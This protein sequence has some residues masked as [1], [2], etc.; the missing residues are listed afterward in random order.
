[1][2]EKIESLEVSSE[3]GQVQIY[4]QDF[5]LDKR[6]QRHQEELDT[7]ERQINEL[8]RQQTEK[9]QQW[10]T[11]KANIDQKYEKEREIQEQNLRMTQEENM[12]INKEIQQTKQRKQKLKQIEKLI[13]TISYTNIQIELMRDFIVPK[14]ALLGDYVE[15]TVENILSSGKFCGLQLDN[16]DIQDIHEHFAGRLPKLTF[17]ETNDAYK[18][19][20]TGFPDHH[21]TFK[22][23]LKRLIT[24]LNS[25]NS[26]KEFYQRYLNRIIK[27]IYGKLMEVKSKARCWRQ[28]I[29]IL[30]ELLEE[31]KIEYINRFN[32]A[33]RE[34]AKS[35]IEQ[36]IRGI[37]DPPWIEL[38]K[39]TNDFLETNLFDNE[40]EELKY[41]ALDEFIKQNISFQRIKTDR[42]PTEESVNM[43]KYYIEQ[44]K[45]TLR[46]NTSYQGYEIQHFSLIPIL[47]QQI[48]IYYSCF[49]MQ[50]PL[51]Q[52]SKDLLNKI[53]THTVT[54]IMTS[55]GSG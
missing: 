49:T 47:L 34:K 38:R 52:L 43:I 18:I 22:A 10:I 45:A 16:D 46:T 29:K 41:R 23:S 54:T 14:F 48:I 55:T 37:F 5:S 20:L 33:S 42:I 32:D 30:M 44:I 39:Y 26:G 17:L 40:I 9:E 3:I 36:S 25:Y 19:N 8:H 6:K 4:E 13:Q 35:L 27:S 51:F 7:A 21:T 12:R 15:Q 50:L 24:L 1:M 53:E 28:Y 2:D 11:I 31:K